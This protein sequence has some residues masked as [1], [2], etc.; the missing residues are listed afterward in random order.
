MRYLPLKQSDKEEMM[1]DIGIKSI[2]DLYKDVPKEDFCKFDLPRKK[3]EQ[4]LVKYFQTLSNKNTD[5]TVASSFLGAG[6]YK[7][8]IPSAVDAI[9]SRSEFLT[10][11]TPYQ[12]E[13]SQGTLA[14]I[15][16]FQSLICE[17]TGMGVAN[18]SMY[19]GATSTVEAILMANR[20]KKKKNKIVIANP[21]N[22]DYKRVI[23]TY[24]VDHNIELVDKVDQDCSCV[25]VQYPDFYGENCNLDKYRKICDE[26]DALLIVV[27]TEIVAL[28][29]IAAPEQADIVVGEAQSLGVGL[30]YGGPHLGYFACRRELVRQTP[31]RICGFTTDADGK[32]S[33]ALTLNAREQHIRRSKATSNICSNQGLNV[34]AFTVHLA[35]LGKD[36]FSKLAKLNHYK[37]KLLHDKL[38]KIEGIT[39]VNKNFFNEFAFES[40]IDADIIIKK[41]LEQ[42]IF[43]GVKISQN[44]ILA[45]VT[46]VNSNEEIENYAKIL[47]EIV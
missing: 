12:P 44:T 26:N 7:H 38:K 17:L 37:T 32:D 9:I 8:F 25:I 30:N 24:I 46:E 41:M 47:A 31:G 29:L 20:I 42:N 6:C 1:Q 10:S 34:V 18:A 21:L 3:T 43:A 23:D 19:D 35:L 36:G 14:V 16:E 27:N 11:Y 28:G 33:F 45:S 5:C 15:F 2:K 39:I 22:P 13:I 4:E 40:K